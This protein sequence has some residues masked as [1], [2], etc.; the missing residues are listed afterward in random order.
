MSISGN[1]RKILFISIWCLVGAGLL[2]LLIAAIRVK[3]DKNCAG[4]NIDIRSAGEL[5]F[6]DKKDIDDG[7][8][9]QHRLN[10]DFLFL[11]VHDKVV[12]LLRRIIKHGVIIHL[13]YGRIAFAAA[14]S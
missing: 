14:L 11:H 4:Y 8:V 5:F 3:Q 13:P 10:R 2:V 1:I 7:A 6:I 12:R 9:L